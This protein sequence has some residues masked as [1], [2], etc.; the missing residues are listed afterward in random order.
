MLGL[1]WR[2]T[3]G[4]Q[5]SCLAALRHHNVIAF[6]SA[7]LASH[8]LFG[9]WNTERGKNKVCSERVESEEVFLQVSEALQGRYFPKVNYFLDEYLIR[10]IICKP[11]LLRMS[12][13]FKV[14]VQKMLKS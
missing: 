8:L 6:L 4:R 1:G 2:G 13:V 9:L 10:N 11:H 12:L 7:G 3:S 5:T 14:D